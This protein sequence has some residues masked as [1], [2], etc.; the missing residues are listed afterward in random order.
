[1]L[2]CEKDVFKVRIN[3]LR[4]I[5]SLVCLLYS[6]ATAFGQV[7][8]SMKLDTNQIFIGEQVLLK[9]KVTADAN[10]TIIMP[11]YPD[12]QLVQGVEVLRH[13]TE[14]SELLNAGKRRVVTEAYQITSFDSALYYIP[15]MVV[16][17]DNDSCKSKQSLALKVMSPSVDTTKVDKIF[18]AMENAEV[19]YDWS[20]FKRPFIFWALGLLLLIAAAYLA[21]Q[22]RNNHRI[23]PKILLK[24]EKPSHVVATKQ[25][26]RLAKKSPQTREEIHAFYSELVEILRVYIGKRYGFRATAMTSA[27][28][29]N[30]LKPLTDPRLLAELSELFESTDLIKYAGI[31]SAAGQESRKVSFALGFVDGTKMIEA[32]N[33]KRKKPKA[34]P[35][36]VRSNLMRTC[37]IFLTSLVALSGSALI[38]WSAYILYNMVF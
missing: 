18:G 21:L 20:D 11:E 16:M 27:Q 15:P 38:A 35:I 7:A 9:L 14:N 32:E 6:G 36:V 1:M 2:A 5:I 17:V 33:G 31:E 13:Y 10:Q 8:V 28:I 25:I 19:V 23:L 26:E 12:S 3:I 24:P 34:D 22:I 37:L 29:L 30:Q 4:Y